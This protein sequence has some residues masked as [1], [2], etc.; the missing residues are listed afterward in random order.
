M[1][2]DEGFTF[3]SLQKENFSAL[4]VIQSIYKSI[5]EKKRRKEEEE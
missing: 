5:K 2:D 1:H 3:D 4:Y